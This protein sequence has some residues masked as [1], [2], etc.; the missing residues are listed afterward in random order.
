ME[1]FFVSLLTIQGAGH[2]ITLTYLKGWFYG[3]ERFGIFP[4]SPSRYLRCSY[5][6]T[7]T[8]LLL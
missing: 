4:M 7:I 1:F 6:K 3:K 5:Q 8:L 2:I